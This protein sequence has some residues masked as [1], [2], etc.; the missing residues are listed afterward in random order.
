MSA[1]LPIRGLLIIFLADK[2]P[3]QY[4][5]DWSTVGFA[6]ARRLTGVISSAG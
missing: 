3:L 4:N 2:R 6:V 5:I 1:R